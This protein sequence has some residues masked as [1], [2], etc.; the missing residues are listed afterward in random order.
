MLYAAEHDEVR[1]TCQGVYQISKQEHRHLCTRIITSGCCH[2]ILH[3]AEGLEQ[4]TCQ[5]KGS[6]E[7]CCWL[8][9][10]KAMV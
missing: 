1:D 8:P 6:F 2:L 3:R 10:H 7:V 4:H 5:N 9:W